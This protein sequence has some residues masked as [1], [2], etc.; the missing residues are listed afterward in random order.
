MNEPELD[1]D[2]LARRL[3]QVT[4]Q[5]PQAGPLVIEPWLLAS[6]KDGKSI[7]ALLTKAHEQA[8]PPT[9][10]VLKHGVDFYYDAVARWSLAG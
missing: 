2:V 9:K 1:L 8:Q 5:D 3:W 7:T 4:G 6:W 10:S